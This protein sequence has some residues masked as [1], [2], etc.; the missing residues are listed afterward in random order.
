LSSLLSTKFKQLLSKWYGQNIVP[1]FH[2]LSYHLFLHDSSPNQNQKQS[3]PTEMIDLISSIPLTT[4]KAKQTKV[5]QSTPENWVSHRHKATTY[6]FIIQLQTK[7]RSIRD[8]R[9]DRLD[10]L[11]PFNHKS[12][13]TNEI[14][15]IISGK[16]SPNLHQQSQL[17]LPG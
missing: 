9:N 12:S 3:E 11:Y 2:P 15:S 1:K 14:L 5:C 6:S 10:L 17:E 4:N 13:Q 8:H 16:S 7:T